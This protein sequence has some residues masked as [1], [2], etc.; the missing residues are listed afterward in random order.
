VG[1]N[2]EAVSEK[3]FW[4]WKTKLRSLVVVDYT[5]KGSQRSGNGE[6]GADQVRTVEKIDANI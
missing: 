5:E 3:I 4:G 1:K 2:A 6:V